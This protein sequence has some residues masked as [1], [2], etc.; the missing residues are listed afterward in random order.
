MRGIG[1]LLRPFGEPDEIG[2][3]VRDF[4]VEE[5]DREVSFAGD[6]FCVDSHSKRISPGREYNVRVS[7]AMHTADDQ[8]IAEVATGTSGDPF[9]VLG[10][11]VVTI[12]QSAGGHRADD[13]AGG[14]GG[15]V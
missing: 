4:L 6:E 12:D 11:H 1:P 10:R 5:P 15:G 3:R 14:L 7:R 9:A 2:D 8:R 13:A